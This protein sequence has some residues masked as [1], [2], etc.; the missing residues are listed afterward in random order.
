MLYRLA[1]PARLEWADYPYSM[2]EAAVEAGADLDKLEWRQAESLAFSPDLLRIA[3][4]HGMRSSV[5]IV[6]SAQHTDDLGRADQ[7]RGLQRKIDRGQD[8]IRQRHGEAFEAL[9]PGWTESGKQL[10][11]EGRAATE[12]SAREA[13]AGL[14]EV[15]AGPINPSLAEHWQECG[16]R[17]PK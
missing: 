16:G 6:L 5:G 7:L 10:E 17:L 4:R 14:A 3:L 12:E 2:I 1:P 15:L 11:A 9:I 13:E 8:Q